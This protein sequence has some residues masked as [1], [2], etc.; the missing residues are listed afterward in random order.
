LAFAVS[1][2]VALMHDIVISIGA[3]SYLGYEVNS[4][5]VIAILTILGY[6]INDT[7]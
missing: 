3:V 5:F 7:V 4:T 6:S 2:I 1:A